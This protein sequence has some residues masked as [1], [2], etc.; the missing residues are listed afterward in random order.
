MYYANSKEFFEI[1]DYIQQPNTLK[2][3]FLCLKDF[4]KRCFFFPFALILKAS[5][6]VIR[7]VGIIFSLALVFVTLGS[8]SIA[9]EV[10]VDRVSSFAKDLADWF[11]LPVAIVVCSC[12]LILAILIHPK[13]YF[14]GLASD[15]L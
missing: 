2:A 11:L 12:R 9:R 4:L 14:N 6:T 15:I 7:A 8:Y 5:K 1:S 3:R 13:F 10:F